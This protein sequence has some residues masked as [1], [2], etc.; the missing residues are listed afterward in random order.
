MHISL[1]PLVY[2]FLL[3]SFGIAGTIFVIANSGL[4]EPSVDAPVAFNDVPKVSKNYSFGSIV[5]G[6]ERMGFGSGAEYFEIE[7]NV[8]FTIRWP[9]SP[10]T[11]KRVFTRFVAY[12]NVSSTFGTGLIILEGG[13]NRD[14]VTIAIQSNSTMLFEWSY[15]VY[16]LRDDAADS[17]KS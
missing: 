14:N 1:C 16:G 12:T 11:P 4:D 6:A 15:E 5:T 9:E 17:I 13:T 10:P 2:S 3:I 8:Q 7:R